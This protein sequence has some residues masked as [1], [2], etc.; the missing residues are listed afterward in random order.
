MFGR[1]YNHGIRREGSCIAFDIGLSITYNTPLHQGTHFIAPCPCGDL[2]SEQGQQER[3][4]L[5]V[6]TPICV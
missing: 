3:I 5:P 6:L 4:L 1:E 2:A